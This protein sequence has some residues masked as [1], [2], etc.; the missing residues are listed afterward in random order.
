MEGK[1][2]ALSREQ[3]RRRRKRC[4]DKCLIFAFLRANVRC[5]RGLQLM[6]WSLPSAKAVF[7]N[8]E[9]CEDKESMWMSLLAQRKRKYRMRAEDIVTVGGYRGKA[10]QMVDELS[11]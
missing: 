9:K 4:S 5:F 10:C 7:P 3:C 1:A 11:V 6:L 8:V 2:G